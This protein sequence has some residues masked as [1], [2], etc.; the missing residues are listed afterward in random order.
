MT[1]EDLNDFFIKKCKVWFN[2]GE[3]FGKAGA[4]FVRLNIAT[5][6][7]VLQEAY[8]RIEREINI[9]DGILEVR[10]YNLEPGEK[11]DIELLYA[12]QR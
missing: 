6:R 12:H 9:L 8:E 3:S 11:L 10:G 4:N 1:N 2:N 7:S 5:S